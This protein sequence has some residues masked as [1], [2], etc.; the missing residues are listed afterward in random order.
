V[1][2]I[3]GCTEELQELPR[4]RETVAP[5]EGRLAVLL[6]AK[7]GKIAV[8][9]P[10]LGSGLFTHA[11]LEYLGGLPSRPGSAVKPRQSRLDVRE[12]LTPVAVNTRYLARS[13]H[14]VEQEP[15]LFE[16]GR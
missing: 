5:G 10:V 6:G 12:L 9:S 1:L 8:E 14:G 4:F 16:M 2:M 15:V 11:L 3:D 13:L 7:I